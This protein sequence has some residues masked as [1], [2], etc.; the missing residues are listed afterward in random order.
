MISDVK[1][2]DIQKILHTL[3]FGFALCSVF[4]FISDYC[5]I[6]LSPPQIG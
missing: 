2:V 1:E 4:R 3:I 5:F 6:I